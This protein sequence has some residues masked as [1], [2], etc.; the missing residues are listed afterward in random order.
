[1][2]SFH[3]MGGKKTGAMCKGESNSEQ[4]QV[5][6]KSQIVKLQRSALNPEHS[7]LNPQ[8]STLKLK[9]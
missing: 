8:P 6:P 4:R 3:W 1:M 9:P 5:N 7:T 2:S